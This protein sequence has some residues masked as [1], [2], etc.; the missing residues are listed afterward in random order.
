MVRMPLGP[1]VLSCICWDGSVLGSVNCSSGKW[2]CLFKTL[3]QDVNSSRRKLSFS[4]K[5]WP[6][7]ELVQANHGLVCTILQSKT[8]KNLHLGFA[9]HSSE[10][11]VTQSYKQKRT[12]K[13]ITRK[14]NH[15]LASPQSDHGFTDHNVLQSHF[16]ILINVIDFPKCRLQ[17]MHL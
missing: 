3:T 4:E 13:K 12:L 8:R 16:G 14:G 6:G 1:S 17:A 11:Q 5:T 7:E 9:G 10:A 15:M 2:K